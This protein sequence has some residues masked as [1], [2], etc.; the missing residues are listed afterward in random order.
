MADLD[1]RGR[2]AH[3]NVSAPESMPILSHQKA[4]QGQ[5][6]ACCR[7][8]HI[9][10]KSVIRRSTVSGGCRLPRISS[11]YGRRSDRLF[12]RCEAQGIPSEAVEVGDLSRRQIKPGCTV[13]G[14][15]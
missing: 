7:S 9:V 10:T 11:T 1:G 6:A 14:L 2:R 3:A 4:W 15:L 12:S 8:P 5:E 13:V